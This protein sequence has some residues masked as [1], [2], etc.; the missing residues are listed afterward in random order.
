MQTS[1][2]IRPTDSLRGLFALLIVWHHLAPMRGIP[3][4]Y[5]F[6]NSIVLFFFV[7]SGFG[8]T[9][10]WQDRINGKS[11]EFLIGRCVKIFPI[12]WFTVVLFVLLGIN[13]VSWW[14]VPFHLTLMHSFVPL[15]EINFTL[16]TPSWFLSS[17][18]FCYLCTPSILRY[19]S[20]HRKS[21]LFLQLSLVACFIVAVYFLSDLMGTRWLAYINPGARLLDYSAGM[22]LG[23]FWKD[24]RGFVNGGGRCIYTILE[25]LFI[26]MM[27]IFMIDAELFKL[28]NYTVLRYPIIIG[29]IAVLSLEKG[30][31]SRLLKN[32]ILGW[33][34][35]ISLGI[36]MTH[37]FILYCT[38]QISCLPV[39]ANV[40]LTYV[41]IVVFA[42]VVTK[43]LSYYSKEL[44][45]MV[46]KI[47]PNGKK[48]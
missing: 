10:S 46:D 34:G 35:T 41:L 43:A 8:I 22:I 19:A 18:F 12:Q 39:W 2:N 48:K 14:A 3:Y 16:N 4:P 30:L 26:S 5:D 11:R 42:Y 37:G 6:G 21:F 28:N 15:W 17:L 31:I 44:Y 13:L 36:Y 1:S 23:L 40:C 9:L 25:I 45:A 38:E 33:L 7:L 20:K 29:L 27:V 24:L 32:R 47:F